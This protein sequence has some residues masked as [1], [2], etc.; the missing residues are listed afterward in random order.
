[1][2]DDEERSEL[3]DLHSKAILYYSAKVCSCV[4]PY[5]QKED[6][7]VLNV[8]FCKPWSILEYNPTLLRYG[9]V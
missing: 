1:M 2:F 9:D 8:L 5:W 3:N 4:D 7:Q 6:L